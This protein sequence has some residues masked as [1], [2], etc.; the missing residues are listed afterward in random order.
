MSAMIIS[1][2]PAPAGAH[3][4][5]GIP[6]LDS[7]GVDDIIGE[8]TAGVTEGID[9]CVGIIVADVTERELDVEEEDAKDGAGCSSSLLEMN[10][11]V[12]NMSSLVGKYV[13]DEVTTGVN[14]GVLVVTI[15]VVDMVLSE[16][17]D[18]VLIELV[19]LCEE[20]VLSCEDD[21]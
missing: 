12:G 11:S 21:D 14:A 15:V 18:D 17:T 6:V 8:E 4:T 2:S 1:A 9:D 7:V 19:V 20:D 13:E 16:D 5:S 10:S 3:I